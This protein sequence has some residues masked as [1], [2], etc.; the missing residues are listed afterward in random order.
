MNLLRTLLAIAHILHVNCHEYYFF[1][2]S[3]QSH[4]EIIDFENVLDDRLRYVGQTREGRPWGNGTLSFKNGDILIGQFVNGIVYGD[5]RKVFNNSN[6][7][8]FEGSWKYNTPWGKGV[9]QYADGSKFT[10][11]FEDGKRQGYGIY[12]HPDNPKVPI[13]TYEGEWKMDL[14]SGLG[15]ETFKNG[16]SYE[17]LFQNGQRHGSGKMIYPLDHDI[18]IFEGTWENG[19]VTG[20]G[21]MVF[22]N[23]DKYIGHWKNGTREGFGSFYCT[24]GGNYTGHWKNNSYH[25]AGI[26]FYSSKSKYD[27]FDGIFDNNI[28]VNPGILYWKNGD[29]YE[30]EFEYFQPSGNG[31]KHFVNADKYEGEFKEGK[32]NGFGSKY[33]ASGDLLLRGKWKDDTFIESE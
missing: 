32:F 16:I 17:G 4:T 12:T 14:P 9:A 1:W 13:R 18:E 15:K 6:L 26:Y 28:I 27:R 29:R 7:L 10:G 25:G 31:T 22:K 20:N 24:C 8:F 33:S 11:V 5:A 3:E 21:T 23:N 30:G 19:T 2:F